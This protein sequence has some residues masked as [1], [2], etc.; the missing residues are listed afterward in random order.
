M[1]PGLLNLLRL[2]APSERAH[3]SPGPRCRTREVHGCPTTPLGPVS[4]QGPGGVSNQTT[5]LPGLS[6][7][8]GL[9]LHAP[10]SLEPHDD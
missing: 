8:P 6:Y 9:L 10:R 2:Q 4:H 7:L 5:T 1:A 3:C